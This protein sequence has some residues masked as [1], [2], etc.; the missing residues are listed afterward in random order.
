MTLVSPLP[1]N[2]HRPFTTSSPIFPRALLPDEK[3][4]DACSLF[5]ELHSE[6]VNSDFYM[7]SF[8]CVIVAAG[9]PCL[10]K[11][12]R[13]SGSEEL[14]LCPKGDLKPNLLQTLCLSILLSPD[15][16][17]QRYYT[18]ILHRGFYFQSI[19]S[20]P[21][22]CQGIFIAFWRCFLSSR[23]NKEQLKCK[24]LCVSVWF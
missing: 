7:T 10:W 2:Q 13:L 4:L 17:Q 11:Y 22:S 24:R 20:L 15:Q 18:L 5:F 1:A 9:K 16:S 14:A 21:A 23:G 8:S 19:D 12:P 6:G 3:H